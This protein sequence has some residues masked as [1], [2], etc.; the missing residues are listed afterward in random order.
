MQHADLLYLVQQGNK[1]QE[2][3]GLESHP[4]WRILDKDARGMIVQA[5]VGQLAQG[6]F[7]KDV[8]VK[9]L[10]VWRKEVRKSIEVT[11]VLSW[12]GV[13]YSKN[14]Y[15]AFLDA[16]PTQVIAPEPEAAP[17]KVYASSLA[18]DLEDDEGDEDA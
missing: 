11:A 3:V 1:A 16:L 9:P 13:Q 18:T 17:S 2:K 10:S 15:R 12:A 14:V 7:D 8:D 4:F 6:D 5:I